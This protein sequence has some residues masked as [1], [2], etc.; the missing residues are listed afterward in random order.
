[1]DKTHKLVL[2]SL[3]FAIAIIL[4][5]IENSL[6]PLPIAVP[7]VKFGLS[8]IAVMYVLFFVGKESAYMVAV[9]KAVF[10]F[11]TRGWIASVLSLTGGILSLTIMILLMVLFREKVS[12][13][14]LSIAGAVFHNIGQLIA[15]SIV[16]TNLYL[17]YFMPVLLVTGVL[18][19][20]VTS[21]LLNVIR[22][23][24]KRVGFNN[25]N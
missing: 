15:V 8:N 4:S 16:Y 24:F 1:M 11:A 23:A 17:M 10:V 18:A 19:G 5:I 21:V 3:F 9:L 25:K 7:G 2:T 6:P 14:I 22:P 20:I 12:Y 13:L